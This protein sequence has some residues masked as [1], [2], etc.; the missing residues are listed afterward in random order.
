MVKVKRRHKRG[1]VHE[2]LLAE[3]ND[4]MDANKENAD[5]GVYDGEDG[6]GVLI[7]EFEVE[8]ETET[9]T[10]MEAEVERLVEKTQA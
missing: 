8:T 10:E 7:D 4:G 5:S 3:T 1:K 6:K 9:E 2:L